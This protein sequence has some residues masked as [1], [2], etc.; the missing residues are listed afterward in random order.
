MLKWLEKNNLTVQLREQQ[1]VH[2]FTEDVARKINV[3][4]VHKDLTIKSE[5]IWMFNGETPHVV[6]GESNVSIEFALLEMI[7][8]ILGINIVLYDN[9][10]RL[11]SP[12]VLA[13]IRVP[14]EMSCGEC[15]AKLSAILD[16]QVA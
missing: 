7:G 2:L 16:E 1:D 8:K 11:A 14:R 10:R 4:L 13:V 6:H 15:A 5:C 3:Q 9:T 12:K